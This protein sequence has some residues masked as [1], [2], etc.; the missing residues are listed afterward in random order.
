M[1]L[2]ISTTEIVYE[3]VPLVR[4]ASA[5]LDDLSA[6]SV[7]SLKK[8]SAGEA[9]NLAA[10]AIAAVIPVYVDIAGAGH[11]ALLSGELDGATFK[12]AASEMV[13]VDG[14]RFRALT[15]IRQD[16]RDALI[17]LRSSGA[18]SDLLS[19]PR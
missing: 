1:S 10:A 16:L 17:I 18:L 6:K 8:M 11:R 5:A 4:A 7:R 15:V 9:L 19:I 2:A 3:Y 13:T 12:R 14:T